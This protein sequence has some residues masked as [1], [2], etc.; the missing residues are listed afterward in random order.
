MHKEEDKKTEVDHYLF[1]EIQQQIKVIS[2]TCN[3]NQFSR[4]TS[5]G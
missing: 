2:C 4:L 3:G 5:Q 1:I